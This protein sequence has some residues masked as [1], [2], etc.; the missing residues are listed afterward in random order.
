MSFFKNVSNKTYQISDN[1]MQFTKIKWYF[2]CSFFNVSGKIWLSLKID[3]HEFLVSRQISFMKY[4]QET[5]D[6]WVLV[7]H[8]FS[9]T[10]EAD[11]SKSLWV[12]GQTSLQEQ[13]RCQ[14]NTE[15]SCLKNQTKTKQQTKRKLVMRVQI[16]ESNLC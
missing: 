6:S 9:P 2:P 15:N 8:P 11:S 14:S 10:Q 12:W 16:I 5:S 7:G 1:F 3:Y 13:D 4:D